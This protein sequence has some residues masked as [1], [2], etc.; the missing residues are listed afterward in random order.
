MLIQA[1]ER[2]S[3]ADGQQFFDQQV[4]TAARLPGEYGKTHS[5]PIM[6]ISGIG[7][8]A[9]DVAAQ[10]FV[11]KGAVIFVVSISSPLDQSMTPAYAQKRK[12]L[13]TA[14]VGRL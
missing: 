8:Q 7:D 9:A 1:Y 4:K 12:T 10:L 13:A 14:I 2:P 3:A 5:A 11:R 6:A